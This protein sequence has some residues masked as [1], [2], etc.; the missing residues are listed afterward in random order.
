VARVT[1]GQSILASDVNSLSQQVRTASRLGTNST[2]GLL[3]GQYGS[4]L[5]A[6]GTRSVDIVRVA[7]RFRDGT[8]V[9]DGAPLR[10]NGDGIFWGK[11][12]RIDA[13][14]SFDSSAAAYSTSDNTT[15]PYVDAE[16]CMIVDLNTWNGTCSPYD[17]MIAGERLLGIRLGSK[18]SLLLNDSSAACFP[19]YGVFPR[20]R[21]GIPFK[22]VSGS[23]MPAHAAMK[24][25]NQG[26]YGDP[27][28]SGGQDASYLLGN[29]PDSTVFSV[30]INPFT[31]CYAVNSGRDV[32]S[33]GY[34]MCITEGVAT[35]LQDNN[36]YYP[37]ADCGPVPGQWSVRFGYP[38]FKYLG[39]YPASSNTYAR[40]SLGPS[41]PLLG[42]SVIDIVPGSNAD[43]V[44]IY[45]YNA[46]S[47]T[48]TTFDPM[49][50]VY[51]F[52]T[53][54]PNDKFVKVTPIS[55][56]WVAENIDAREYHFTT[57]SVGTGVTV[58]V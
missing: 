22:N 45:S 53:T 17:V 24:V 46:G 7:G 36:L 43:A 30:N 50:V 10:R 44:K 1:P 23:T 21:R 28:F 8:I 52:G 9:P 47:P 37:G 12:Q 29:Q 16:D 20:E 54:I 31:C 42:K 4:L 58:T 34:G 55:G 14:N 48:A 33:G 11:V 6:V 3:Q 38:G 27:Y 19:L 56:F 13:N 5:S 40:V 39:S 32:P 49:H 41:F 2:L 57:P 26:N 18:T 15:L 51:N 35:V 25:T